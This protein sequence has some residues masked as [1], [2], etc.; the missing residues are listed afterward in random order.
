MFEII[1]IITYVVTKKAT[2]EY[3]FYVKIYTV[4]IIIYRIMKLENN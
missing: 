3:Y 2:N 4:H 1:I